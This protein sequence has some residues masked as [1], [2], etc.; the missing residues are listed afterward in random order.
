ML[1]PP[2]LFHCHGRSLHLIETAVAAA[3]YVDQARCSDQP[4]FSTPVE[5][6]LGPS[7]FFHSRGM[8]TGRTE[9][10]PLATAVA[11]PAS[12]TARW[13]HQRRLL[14]PGAAAGAAAAM[15][16]LHRRHDHL[17]ETYFLQ[18]VSFHPSTV[19]VHGC[20]DLQRRSRPPSTL[21][22]WVSEQGG[23]APPS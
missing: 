7:T 11:V 21:P 14:V 1:W 22:T 15:A 13:R 3:P 20:S 6:R 23:M 8:K 10:R 16:R 12:S 19:H 17:T 4:F 18:S 9:P 5:L 2:S